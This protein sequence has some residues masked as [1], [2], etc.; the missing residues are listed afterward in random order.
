MLAEEA[1]KDK[2]GDT[3]TTGTSLP[4]ALGPVE[5]TDK[6]NWKSGQVSIKLL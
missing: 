2:T 4:E 3:G 1:G 5:H 6:V